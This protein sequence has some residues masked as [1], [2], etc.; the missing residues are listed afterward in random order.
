MLRNDQIT[1]KSRHETARLAYLASKLSFSGLRVADV[2]GNTGFFSFELLDRGAHRVDYYEGN[3]AHHDFVRAA[4][5][6]LGLG[7]RLR[8]FNRYVTFTQDELA[9]TDCTLLL[10]V[11]HHLGADFGDARLNKDAAKQNI[12]SCLAALSRQTRQLVFQLGFNWKG[13]R[14]QPLFDHGTKAKLIDFVTQGTAADWTIQSVGV[15][16]KSGDTVTFHDLNSANLA[17]ADALG[18][19]LNRPIFI[20]RSKHL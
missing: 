10:N 12:L 18:E 13:D 11:L 5:Q 14:H 17:R 20:M 19:F 3:K 6:Q 15:A 16:E 1:V 7:E 2:G 8:T 9:G 4:A